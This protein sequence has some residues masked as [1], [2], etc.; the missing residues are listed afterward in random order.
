MNDHTFKPGDRVRVLA[1][2]YPWTHDPTLSY[3]GKDGTVRRMASGEVVMTMDGDPPNYPPM[4]FPP[5]HVALL[6]DE[7]AA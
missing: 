4:W 7:A 2:V 1:D 3:V 6:T 5:T